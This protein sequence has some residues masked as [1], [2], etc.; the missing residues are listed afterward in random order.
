HFSSSLF[1]DFCAGFKFRP[2]AA[3]EW[4]GDEFKKKRNVHVDILGGRDEQ[5]GGT[6][7]ACSRS[8][9][10]AFLTNVMELHESLDAKSRGELPLLFLESCKTPR[11]FA[12]ELVKEVNQYNGFNLIISDIL[13]ST[14]VYISNRLNGEASTIIQDVS[15]GLHV[16][17]NAH[18][19]SP[20]PKAQKLGLGFKE[21]LG[22]YGNG[23]IPLKEIAKK[24]MGDRSKAEKKRLPG[25]FSADWE[26]AL[27]SIFVEVNTPQGWC[28]TRSTIAL[29]VA[30]SGE[31]SFNETYLEDGTWKE[32]TINYQIQ[33]NTQKLIQLNN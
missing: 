18:L 17:S 26:S 33:K 13:S 4:W 28:G 3:V 23:E 5:A 10:V 27:S 25:I 2:T 21:Q 9:R 32:K 29:A 7:L 1:A 31:V 30:G 12:E 14:M 8:G 19:D 20:W 24:L 6:W 22:K 15:P 16:L 11:E